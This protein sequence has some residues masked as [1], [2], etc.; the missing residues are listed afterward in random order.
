[1]EAVCNECE[2][3]PHTCTNKI[4][5]SVHIGSESGNLIFEDKKKGCYKYKLKI[6]YCPLCGQRLKGGN[7][8]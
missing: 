3:Q 2:S 4:N 7:A 8:Q 1:M 5:I 6:N